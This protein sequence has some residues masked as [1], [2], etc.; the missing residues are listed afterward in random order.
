MPNLDGFD[1]ARKIRALAAHASTPI[2]AMTANAFTEDREAALA[3][4]MNDH[5]AKPIDPDALYRALQK[6][7]P[8]DAAETTVYTFQP[9]PPALQEGRKPLTEADAALLERLSRIPGLSADSGLRTV[10]GNVAKLGRF[11]SRFARDHRQDADRL[12]AEWRRHD[13]LG[14]IRCAHTLKGVAGAFGLR[15][16]Q[17]LAT[18]VETALKNDWPPKQM[19]A[20]ITRLESVLERC[21]AEFSEIEVESTTATVDF[22][23]DDLHQQLRALHVLLK[24]D[25]LTAIDQYSVLRSSVERLIPEPARR[26]NGQIEDFAFEEAL[27]TLDE[28]LDRDLWT[29]ANLRRAEM[30]N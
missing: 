17:A 21:C 28:I 5:L 12:R 1:A 6:W 15:E 2:L 18:E 4:G 24:A 26:L 25:D 27:V 23:L 22:D 30:P 19:E 29:D 9:S 11:L 16:L 7:L 3:A 10:R 20:A 13:S 8:V 14:A